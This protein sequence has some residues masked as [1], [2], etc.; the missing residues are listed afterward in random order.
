MIKHDAV[1]KKQ[2]PNHPVLVTAARLRFGMALK[3]SI[4]AAAR[5]GGRYCDTRSQVCTTEHHQDG[6]IQ[7]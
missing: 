1:T 6:M 5:D 4:W 2:E 3:G 7:S